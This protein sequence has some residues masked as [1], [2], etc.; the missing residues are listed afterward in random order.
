MKISSVE[1]SRNALERGHC[2]PCGSGTHYINEVLSTRDVRGTHGVTRRQETWCCPSEAQGRW[3]VR[4][5][6]VRDVMCN[7]L[8]A[9]LYIAKMW[10]S[11][12]VFQN[13]RIDD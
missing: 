5:R 10:T 3:I 1:K 9:V 4:I 7:I 11:S 2:A 12:R 8:G 6:V 13:E